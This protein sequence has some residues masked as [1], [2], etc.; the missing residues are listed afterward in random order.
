[1]G[2]GAG[3]LRGDPRDICQEHDFSYWPLCLCLA[4]HVGTRYRWGHSPQKVGETR[5]ETLEWTK[6]DPA[7]SLA[8]EAWSTSWFCLSALVLA[9]LSLYLRFVHIIHL[10]RGL[11]LRLQRGETRIHAHVHTQ[12]HT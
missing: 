3:C 5:L 10:G 12:V 9:S 6:R 2:T 4:Y 7:L 11:G 1:M 8:P